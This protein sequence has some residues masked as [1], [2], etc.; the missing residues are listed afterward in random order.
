MIWILPLHLV[1]R[2]TL[3]R[4][5]AW[6]VLKMLISPS[7]SALTHTYTH[8]RGC[9]GGGAAENWDT[10]CTFLSS[11]FSNMILETSFTTSRIASTAAAICAF[12]TSLDPAR[13]GEREAT[14]AQNPHNMT[15]SIMPCCAEAPTKPLAQE[16]QYDMWSS[17]PRRLFHFEEGHCAPRRI[18]MVRSRQKSMTVSCENGDPGIPSPHGNGDLSPQSYNY[19][20]GVPIFM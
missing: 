16:L 13:G 11:S 17:N 14:C 7:T 9:V 10:C 20:Y 12:S 4:Y 2:D 19:N 6:D 18:C 1:Y 15:T 5:W 3:L 8:T